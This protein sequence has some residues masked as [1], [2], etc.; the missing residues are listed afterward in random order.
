MPVVGDFGG[1][2]AIKGVGE[3]VRREGGV[4]STFYSSNVE[5]YLSR[6]QKRVFCK[7]LM[8]LPHDSGTWF[9]ESR[10]L[11]PLRSKLNACAATEPSLHWR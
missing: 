10:K 11:Q 9:I 5:V 3:Y 6:D 4:I 7:S 1:P 8:D 2:N